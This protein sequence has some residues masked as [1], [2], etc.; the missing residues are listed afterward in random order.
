M[1][2]NDIF[3]TYDKPVPFKGLK[4]YPVK[5]DNYLE[6]TYYSQC[7]LVEKNSF[8]PDSSLSKEEKIKIISM[9]ELEYLFL[10]SDKDTSPFL[11]MLIGLLYLCLGLKKEDKV[12]FD[13][14]DGGKPFIKINE[15]II[16]AQ[17]FI[18]I[19]NIIC[20]QNL[21]ELPDFTIQ[22]E[23][24][25]AMKKAKQ[26]E[27]ESGGNKM[28]SLEDLFVCA[29]VSTPLNLEQ[30]YNLTIRKFMKIIQ[31]VDLKLHYQIYLSA[32]LSGM[33][34]FKDKSFIKHW[35]AEIIPNKNDGL[36]D[37]ESVENKINNVQ[38]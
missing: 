1:S 6:F 14:D 32:S 3:F 5:M 35:M 31:R 29:L 2:Y 4:I 10:N 36:L 34:T 27:A 12:T 30:L 22:K 37:K 24:R 19:K 17:D 18:E 28:A 11:T 9:S 38:Q 33:V 16:N 21:V 23:V 8:S 15:A 25:D 13:F 7:L 20:E 26:Y